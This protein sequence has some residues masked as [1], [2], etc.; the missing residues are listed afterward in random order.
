MGMRTLRWVP[1]CVLGGFMRCS[2]VRCG[3]RREHG[4][5][6]PKGVPCGVGKP[7]LRLVGADMRSHILRDES[8]IRHMRELIGRLPGG[9][10]V[11]DLDELMLQPSIRARTR[12]WRRGEQLVAFALVDDYNNLKFDLDPL[13]ASPQLEAQ[14]VEWGLA[15]LRKRNA[16]SGQEHT[17]DASCAASNAARIALL[18]RHGFRRDSIRSLHYARS[19]NVPV[20]DHP[21]P[22]GFR[23]RAARGE[24]E[25]E[26][27]VALH[28]AASGTASMSVEA[29]LAIMRAPQ[30]LPELDLVAVAPDGELAAFCICWF[31]DAS[32]K[33]GYTDPIGTH[34]RYQRRGLG[35]AVV[36]AGLRA[37]QERGAETAR[38]TTSSENVAMQRLAEAMGFRMV[39]ESLWFSRAVD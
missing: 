28:H 2:Q 33:V 25:V 30:Y 7:C 12:L 18:E 22:G 31:E 10:S 16:A 37:L 3:R 35:K 17:L 23:L 1:V 9:S 8:D 11:V 21:L 29:R 36:T 5:R 26:A 14:I 20:P 19:Q 32:R 6:T 34:A 15:C 39:W 38:L 13:E 24:G 4:S 27:L